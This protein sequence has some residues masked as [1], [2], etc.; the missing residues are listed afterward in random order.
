MASYEY[1]NLIDY[2]PL[3]GEE[4]RMPAALTRVIHEFTPETQRQLRVALNTHHMTKYLVLFCAQKKDALE[5]YRGTG[6]S[7]AEVVAALWR[8]FKIKYD[9]QSVSSIFNDL[10][11]RKLMKKIGLKIYGL[12]QIGIDSELDVFLKYIQEVRETPE[13]IPEKFWDISSLDDIPFP[14][15]VN[16]KPSIKTKVFLSNCILV[17]EILQD[18]AKNYQGIPISAVQ[19]SV[20]ARVK[21]NTDVKKNKLTAVLRHLISKEWV[22]KDVVNSAAY[23]LTDQGELAINKEESALLA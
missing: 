13:N 15:S 16:K 8:R 1:K 7:Q 11:A 22:S 12:T 23:L 21:F 20:L 9:T 5:E 3:Y 6:I 4:K 19:I 17:L 2:N 10:M 18:F 14:I